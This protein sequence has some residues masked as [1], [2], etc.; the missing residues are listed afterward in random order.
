MLYK[1]CPFWANIASYNIII[2]LQEGGENMVQGILAN[3]P[4]VVLLI[5]AILYYRSK[6]HAI[7]KICDHP[8]LSDDKVKYI[9]KMM[10]KQH[11]LKK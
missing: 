1:I 2:L 10:S 7:N 4:S 9:T 6:I 8:E 11:R 5:V 3:L